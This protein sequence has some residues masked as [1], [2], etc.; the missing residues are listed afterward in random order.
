MQ[1]NSHRKQTDDAVARSLNKAGIRA[2]YHHSTLTTVK[3]P[4]AVRLLDWVNK[5]SRTQ[6]QEGFTFIGGNQMED[7]A[8][9]VA[10]GMHLTGRACW[11]L[12]LLRF[13]DLLKNDREY[14]TDRMDE[15][16]VLVLTNAGP[17]EPG[18]VVFER[19][20]LRFMEMLLDEWIADG[21]RLLLHSTLPMNAGWFSGDFLQRVAA[22]NETITELR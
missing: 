5:T 16:Q 22:L 13:A 18:E 12:P 6:V 10:R 15:A 2:R 20:E 9:I 14:L 17:K 7:L 8:I 21:N 19:R 3:H 4:E 1:T 11:V